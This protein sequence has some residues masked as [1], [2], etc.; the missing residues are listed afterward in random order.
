MNEKQRKTNPKNDKLKE[1]EERIL[2]FI[3]HSS[4]K[5][6]KTKPFTRENNLKEKYKTIRDSL[7]LLKVNIKKIIKNI[8]I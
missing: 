7:V 6:I 4:N 8:I 3:E 5:K 2:T 1:I